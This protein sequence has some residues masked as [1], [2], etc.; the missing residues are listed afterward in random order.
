[1]DAP[2]RVP[3]IEGCEVTSRRRSLRSTRRFGITSLS[4]VARRPSG[5]RRGR[6]WARQR[7]VCARYEPRILREPHDEGGSL[8]WLLRQLGHDVGLGTPERR[9]CLTIS[10]QSLASANGADRLWPSS[11]RPF[12][13]RTRRSRRQNRR[14]SPC[15]A[16]PGRAGAPGRPAGQRCARNFLRARA[17]L[18]VTPLHRLPEVG[19][20]I[21]HQA[22]GLT[23][24]E[25]N[26]ARLVIAGKSMPEASAELG[27]SAHTTWTHLRL[28]FAK[29]QTRSQSELAVMLA[30]LSGG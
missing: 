14:P 26:L 11:C 30:R 20:A 7:S 24:A 10:A 8:L 19:E 27:I 3:P 23:Q 12:A 17:I 25:V 4:L 9:F 13:R 6:W 16:N 2:Y 18:L 28:M 15:A 22:F 21:L 5:F 1:M 29:T